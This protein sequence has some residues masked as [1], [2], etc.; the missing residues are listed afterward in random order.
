MLS[1]LEDSRSVEDLE[2]TVLFKS[3]PIFTMY[4]NIIL[5]I[6]KAVYLMIH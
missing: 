4:F 5:R 2:S 1:L 3:S 6:S